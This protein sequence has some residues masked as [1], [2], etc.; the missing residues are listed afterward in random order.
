MS[1]QSFVWD[2]IQHP[3]HIHGQ[4]FLVLSRS[5]I[6]NKLSERK[7]IPSQKGAK[8]PPPPEGDQL[9]GKELIKAGVGN[10]V[11]KDTALIKTGDTVEFPVE[12]SNPG[13]WMIHCH[14]AEHLQ[15]GTMMKFKIESRHRVRVDVQRENRYNRINKRYGEYRFFT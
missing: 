5:N 9:F 13:T 3:I 8:D 10:L 1:S 15:A 11:W 6:P 12:M 14:I 2:P 4:C 7:F